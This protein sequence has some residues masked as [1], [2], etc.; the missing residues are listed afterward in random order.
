M[1]TH[2]VTT[3]EAGHTGDVGKVAFVDGVAEVDETTHAGELAYF[4]SAGYGVEELDPAEEVDVDGDGKV[5]K[6]PRRNASE[7]TWRA[8]AVEH[9]MTQEE[10]DSLGRDELVAHFSSKK[11]EDQ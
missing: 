9:G 1:A 2:K 11:E 5:E 6:L 3:P 4:R 8:F 10:A 7:A